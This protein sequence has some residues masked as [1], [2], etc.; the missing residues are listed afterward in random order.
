M[1]RAPRLA[2]RGRRADPLPAAGS[3]G[4]LDHVARQGAG[5][6]DI[7]DAIQAIE[8]SPPAGGILEVVMPDPGRRHD[9]PAEDEEGAVVIPG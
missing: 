5:L 1:E 8:F 6:L 2:R 3:P 7:D 4:Q 9:M